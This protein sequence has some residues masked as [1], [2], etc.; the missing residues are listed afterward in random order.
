MSEDKIIKLLMKGRTLP[1][2]SEYLKEKNVRPSSLSYLEKLL[3]AMKDEHKAKTMFHLGAILS[4]KAITKKG[5][6]K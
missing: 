2:I 5:L 6:K 4:T 3:K 1:E